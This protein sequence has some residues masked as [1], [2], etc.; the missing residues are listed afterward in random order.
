MT[1]ETQALL[2][3]IPVPDP[4]V[5][6]AAVQVSGDVPSPINPP[7]GCHFHPRCA[8]AMACC[9]DDFPGVVALSSGHEVRC[10]LFMG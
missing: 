3:A 6:P 4:T 9:R 8:R 7:S 2:S 10:F 1:N 5:R